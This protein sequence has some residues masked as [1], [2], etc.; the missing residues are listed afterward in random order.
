MRFEDY[1]YQNEA[2]AQKEPFG[3]SSSTTFPSSPAERNENSFYT[4]SGYSSFSTSSG[5]RTM[6]SDSSKPRGPQPSCFS[7]WT[8]YRYT[9]SEYE[10]SLRSLKYSPTSPSYSPT[11]PSYSPTSPSYNPTSPSYSPTSPTYSPTSPTYSPTSPSYTVSSSFSTV[12]CNSFWSFLEGEGLTL[13]LLIQ[14]VLVWCQR[15]PNTPE[16]N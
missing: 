1:E 11:S 14:N 15:T 6:S 10:Y 7:P 9:S 8:P 5:F 16:M 3:K 13:C 12:R 4:S 2:D